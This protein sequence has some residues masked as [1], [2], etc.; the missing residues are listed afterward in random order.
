MDGLTTQSLMEL[1]HGQLK[2][3]YIVAPL[4]LCL[5]KPK[6]PHIANPDNQTFLDV[7]KFNGPIARNPEVLSEKFRTT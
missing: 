6:L 2:L 5:T 4:M 1:F 7:L 3:L